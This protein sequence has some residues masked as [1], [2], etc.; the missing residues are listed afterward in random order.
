MVL[1]VSTVLIPH[2]AASKI[3]KKYI[4][5]LKKYPPRPDLSETIALGTRGT[6]KGIIIF[7]V[8]NVKKGKVE[9]TIIN[10]TGQNQEYVAAI[11][12]LKWQLDTYMDM[13]EAYKAI[14]ME[15]PE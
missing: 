11:D 12:G 14:G 5:M 7:S 1:L 2:A 4:E 15:A 13:T 10:V 6:K 9:E 3:A 8:M